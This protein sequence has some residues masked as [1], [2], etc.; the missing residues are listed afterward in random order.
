MSDVHDPAAR[1]NIMDLVLITISVDQNTSV[2]DLIKQINLRLLALPQMAVTNPSLQAPAEILEYELVWRSY[3]CLSNVS[4]DYFMPDDQPLVFQADISFRF[5][6]P[7]SHCYGG[8][9]C[10]KEQ[11]MAAMQKPCILFGSMMSSDGTETWKNPA[12]APQVRIIKPGV[13]VEGFCRSNRCPAQDMMVIC[14]LG[15]GAF[16]FVTD[17]CMRVRCPMCFDPIEPEKCAFNKCEWRYIG[18]KKSS[19]TETVNSSPTETVKSLE[20][21]LAGEENEQF[22]SK[23]TE[24]GCWSR[25]LISSRIPQNKA[26]NTECPVC[27]ENFSNLVADPEIVTHCKHRFHASCIGACKEIGKTTCPTCS[28]DL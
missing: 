22:S 21:C 3:R 9:T 15:M 20:W 14:N 23:E 8:G 5:P 19:P 25:L 7:G 10:F 6:T 12:C 1:N 11:M 28:R 4:L 17:A 26:A 27:L 13:C 18:T 16:D 24:K 2:A